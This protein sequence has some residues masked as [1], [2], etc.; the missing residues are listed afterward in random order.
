MFLVNYISVERF[1]YSSFLVCCSPCSL[2]QLVFSWPKVICQEPWLL[3]PLQH[4]GL[5]PVTT[6]ATGD[7]SHA[8]AR[9]AT[10]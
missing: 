4:V 5:H 8:P 1:Y 6:A 10:H 7:P 9:E 3:G 2:F